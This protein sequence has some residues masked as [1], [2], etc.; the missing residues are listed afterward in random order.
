MEIVSAEGDRFGRLDHH[1]RDRKR[2]SARVPTR[3]KKTPSHEKM[4]VV[5]APKPSVAAFSEARNL[6]VEK[7]LTGLRSAMTLAV[8]RLFCGL[9]GVSGK[10]P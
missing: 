6:R 4:V 8:G 9:C 1:H 3:G 2:Q 10:D 5:D 7:L